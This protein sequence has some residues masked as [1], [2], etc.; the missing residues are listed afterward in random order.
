MLRQFPVRAGLFRSGAPGSNELG[1]EFKL[2]K[3][4]SLVIIITFN[5]LLQVRKYCTPC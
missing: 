4:T 3:M 5:M 2:P 1:E